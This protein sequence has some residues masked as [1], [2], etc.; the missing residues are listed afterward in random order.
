M[1][2]WLGPWTLLPFYHPYQIQEDMT[3]DPLG[4]LF[5]LGNKQSDWAYHR[6]ILPNSEVIGAHKVTWT[7]YYSAFLL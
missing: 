6:C 4:K 3:Q 7:F 5:I 2:S 1:A